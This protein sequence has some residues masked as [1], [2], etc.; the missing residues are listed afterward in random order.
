MRQF[1][2]LMRSRAVPILSGALLAILVV[3]ATA[4][5]GGFAGP[6]GVYH[7]A[8]TASGGSEGSEG[9]VIFLG[10][11]AVIAVAVLSVAIL[12]RAGAGRKGAKRPA[13]SIRRKPAGI[14]S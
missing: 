11:I 7:R 14:A 5:A 9:A 8:L 10:V 2:N 6:H 13:T 4:L 3:P 12:S 1:R